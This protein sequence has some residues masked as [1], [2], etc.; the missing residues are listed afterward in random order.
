MPTKIKSFKV[1]NKQR[2][3][4]TGYPLLKFDKRIYNNDQTQY[5]RAR[6]NMKQM[7]GD[8]WRNKYGS[9]HQQCTHLLFLLSIL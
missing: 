2:G 7:N 4:G 5:L 1:A 9:Y 3:F 8:K 6:K